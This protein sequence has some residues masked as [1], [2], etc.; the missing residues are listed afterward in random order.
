MVVTTTLVDVGNDKQCK[1]FETQTGA[2]GGSGARFP[3]FLL[4]V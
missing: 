3:V 1:L 2:T 4:L